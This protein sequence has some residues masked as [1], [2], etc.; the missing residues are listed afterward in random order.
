MSLGMIGTHRST[1]EEEARKCNHGNIETI[2]K[3][4]NMQDTIKCVKQ[5][6][7]IPH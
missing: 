1:E 7:Y 3:Q 2:S 5:W 4:T 6:H